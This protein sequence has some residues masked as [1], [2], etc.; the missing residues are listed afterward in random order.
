MSQEQISYKIRKAKPRDIDQLAKLAQ[1]G[2]QT[3]PVYSFVRTK[4]EQY[5]KDTVKSYREELRVLAANPK[6]KFDVL[7]L[8]P[9]VDNNNSGKPTSQLTRWGKSENGGQKM[10]RWRSNCK[11]CDSP[12]V[13]FAIWR[14]DSNSEKVQRSIWKKAK[15]GWVSVRAQL[16]SLVWKP[17]DTNPARAAKI[18]KL[19]DE[20]QRSFGE[21]SMELEQM[22]VHPKFQRQG[23]GTKLGREGLSIAGKED[24]AVWVIATPMGVKLYESLGF[25]HEKNVET[26]DGDARCSL[27]VQVW[28]VE[29]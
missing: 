14:L 29:D 16:T 2:Y 10:P 23:Y 19:C 18:G 7:E 12:I 5:Q 3:S 9:G 17:R 4:A 15:Y 8:N 26:V 20:V 27:A 22:V 6:L 25:C 21:G 11:Q 24:L 1:K 28:K 13:G